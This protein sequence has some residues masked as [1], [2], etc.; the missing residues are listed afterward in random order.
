MKMLILTGVMATS[1]LLVGC[2]KG[3]TAVS[4]A[5]PSFTTVDTPLK[6]LVAQSPIIVYAN[7]DTNNLPNI[8]FVI[9]EVWK[10]SHDA[11]TAGC[12]IGTQISRQWL[13]KYGTLP[14]GAILFYRRSIPSSGTYEIAANYMVR[15]GHIGGTTTMT[16]QQFKIA[17]GL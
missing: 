8:H 11:S 14:D 2:G 1:I 7:A 10:G 3:G 12:D 5:S 13:A 15:A 17:F 16:I 9:A 4:Y 6:E